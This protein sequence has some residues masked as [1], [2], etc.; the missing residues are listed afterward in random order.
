[1]QTLLLLH[2]ALGISTIG[3][4]LFALAKRQD[5]RAISWLTGLFVAS[6]SSGTLLALT[7]DTSIAS[8][9]ARL[10]A[11]TAVVLGAEYLLL[12]NTKP[13]LLRAV[14]TLNLSVLIA[15]VLLITL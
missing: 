9:C 6:L 5:V 15:S 13:E 12:K 11:Y 2:V 7:G 10:G 4:A 3:Y 1:M 8:T 14:T